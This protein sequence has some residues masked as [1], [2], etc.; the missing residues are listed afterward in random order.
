MSEPAAAGVQLPARLIRP[1]GGVAPGMVEFTIFGPTCD[2]P[3]LLPHKVALPTD[4]AEGDWI[5]FGQIGAYSNSMA[6][7]FNGFTSK[8]FVSVD[9]PAFLP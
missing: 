2:S 4:A 9:A 7:R 3:D 5:E 6:T 1:G 8:T